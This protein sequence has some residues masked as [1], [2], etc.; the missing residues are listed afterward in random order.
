M[1]KIGFTALIIMAFISGSV[2]EKSTLKNITSNHRIT[3]SQRQTAKS[4][5]VDCDLERF[6][7][8]TTALS[9]GFSPDEADKMSYSIYFDCMSYYG[10]GGPSGPVGPAL[11]AKL[12]PIRP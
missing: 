5:D 2:A 12:E 6:K 4:S 11:P 1:K 7:A 10:P 3:K 8:K 9:H